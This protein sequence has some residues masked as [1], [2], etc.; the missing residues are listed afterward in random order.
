MDKEIRNITNQIKR[1]GEDSRLVE[2]VAIVFNSDSQ[3]LGFIERINPNAI[4]Q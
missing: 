3:D 4:T 1:S 2:G